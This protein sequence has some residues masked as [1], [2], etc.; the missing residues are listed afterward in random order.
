MGK[1]WEYFTV[2]FFDPEYKKAIAYLGS[3]S[4][5]NENKIENAGLTAV[6][7]GKTMGFKEAKQTFLC[8]KLCKQQ[9]DK[10]SFIQEIRD[11]YEQ[12]PDV[13]T[14]GHGG[15]EPHFILLGEIEEVIE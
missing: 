2:S 10:N 13:Y 9:F 3:H 1:P 5:R 12:Y 11:Y 7:I 8:K 4:G 6:T 15:W 14:D